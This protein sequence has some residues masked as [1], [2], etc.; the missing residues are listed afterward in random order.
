MLIDNSYFWVAIILLACGTFIVRASFILL[1][2]RLTISS[3]VKEVFSF[4]PAAI[5]PA[6]VT[7][8]AYYHEGQIEIILGKERFIILVLATVVCYFTKSML[9]TIFFGLTVLYIVTQIVL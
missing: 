3:R 9:A 7:P 5:L 4:I 2:S 6:I 1:S 8:L